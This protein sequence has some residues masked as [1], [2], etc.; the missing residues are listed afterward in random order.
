MAD[1]MARTSG[2]LTHAATAA[3]SF[4][5]SA[6]LEAWSEAL[7]SQSL[8]TLYGW[9]VY[10]TLFFALLMLLWDIPVVRRRVKHIP[11]WPLV[12][13]RQARKARR[14]QKLRRIKRQRKTLYSRLG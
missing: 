6:N 9:V 7:L 14:W 5:S 8:K 1:G 3:T 2:Y 10:I 4:S 12:G 13:L 11:T